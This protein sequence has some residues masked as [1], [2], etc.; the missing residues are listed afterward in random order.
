MVKNIGFLLKVS[1]KGRDPLDQR[2]NIDKFLSVDKAGKGSP[3]H[4]RTAVGV[5]EL[6]A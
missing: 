2:W 3:K 1:Y 4:I 5:A 6:S